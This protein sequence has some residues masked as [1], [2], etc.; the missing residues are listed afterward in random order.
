[1]RRGGTECHQLFNGR[2]TG[3][4]TEEMRMLGGQ[5]SFYLGK[6]KDATADM[7]GTRY[8]WENEMRYQ[9]RYR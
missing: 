1:M 7:G 3:G 6:M 2:E 4:R 9:K 5:S 8:S